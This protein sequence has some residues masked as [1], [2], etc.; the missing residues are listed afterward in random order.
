MYREQ[1]LLS[2]IITTNYTYFD[3]SVLILFLFFSINNQF[4]EIFHISHLN[5]CKSLIFLI[6]I[7]ILT[8]EQRA[9]DWPT[10]VISWKLNFFLFDSYLNI[11][12]SNYWIWIVVSL[13]DREC[14][15]LYIPLYNLRNL[16]TQYRGFVTF[17]FPSRQLQKI[18]LKFR[19]N[20]KPAFNIC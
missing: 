8:S 11:K 13:E 5:F 10:F 2:K 17:L 1:F 15:F 14:Q 9:H 19:N 16:T 18:W 12:T 20:M 3:I 6:L 4:F 7:L